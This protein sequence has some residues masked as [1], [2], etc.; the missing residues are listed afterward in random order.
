MSPVV[1]DASAAVEIILNTVT[2]QQLRSSVA[3]D[4]VW[5]P[6]HFYIE[7]AGVFRRMQLNNAITA[8]NGGEAF[9]ELIA[10]RTNRAQVKTLLPAAWALRANIT[11][12]DAVYVVLAQQLAAPLVT[13]DNRLG[14]APPQ[15]LG[16][17]QV[18]SPIS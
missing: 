16:G 6:E 18:I 3:A 5:V 17:I 13:G 14:R 7:V 4:D 8:T 15:A 12:A 11:V 10:L 9:T 1:L 2:G